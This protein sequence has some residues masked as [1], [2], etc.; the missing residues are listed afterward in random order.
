MVLAALP[1]V[2]KCRMTV[3]L[4]AVGYASFCIRTANG[5]RNRFGGIVSVSRRQR[6]FPHA[7]AAWECEFHGLET[8]DPGF[9]TLNAPG[10][11][12]AA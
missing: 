7:G 10:L 11:F 12:P 3:R 8:R 1:P 4:R 6:C 5:C 2:I 9:G